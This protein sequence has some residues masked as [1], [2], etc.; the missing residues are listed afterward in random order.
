MFEDEISNQGGPGQQKMTSSVVG[1]VTGSTTWS[2]RSLR[3]QNPKKMYEEVWTVGFFLTASVR[4]VFFYWSSKQNLF[5]RF[6]EFLLFVTQ[7]M[8]SRRVKQYL[9]NLTIIQ[10]EEKLRDMSQVCEPPQ[11]SGKY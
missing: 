8:M 9:S 2:R 10:D 6:M 7:S 5:H 4:K 3:D 1:M 11:G